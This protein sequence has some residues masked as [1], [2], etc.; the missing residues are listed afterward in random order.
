[1]I[2]FL[3]TVLFLQYLSRKV[4]LLV[5]LLLLLMI[6]VTLSVVNRNAVPLTPHSANLYFNEILFPTE[7]GSNLLKSCVCETVS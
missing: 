7:I 1:M 4:I 5:L 2:C 6:Q 3:L